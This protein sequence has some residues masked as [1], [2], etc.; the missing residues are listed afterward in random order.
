MEPGFNF[1]TYALFGV[2]GLACYLL[3]LW[4]GKSEGYKKAL[5]ELARR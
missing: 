1:I 2:C 4:A 5:K 3:G